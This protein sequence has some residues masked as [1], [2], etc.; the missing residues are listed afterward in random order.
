[1]NETMKAWAKMPREDLKAIPLF[2]A[3]GFIAEFHPA[4]KRYG[5]I[6][7]EYCPNNGVKF[8]KGNCSVRYHGSRL[9]N[10]KWE[11]WCNNSK[12]GDGVKKKV[13]T[14]DDVQDVIELLRSK[15]NTV[16]EAVIVHPPPPTG[17]KS[18]AKK[19][20]RK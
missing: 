5:R 14:F 11:V 19:I 20:K 7:P 6:T 17:K 4:D 9:H 18:R 10:W 15:G 8:R 2:N 13:G 1:M 12:T 3:A 16:L